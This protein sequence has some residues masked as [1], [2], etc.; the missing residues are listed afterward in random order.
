MRLTENE[1]IELEQV[2]KGKSRM[3]LYGVK[4]IPQKKGRKC[5]N[6]KTRMYSKNVV[7]KTDPNSKEWKLYVAILKEEVARKNGCSF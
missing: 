1:K 6:K 2:E 7:I 3:G 4:T 5:V